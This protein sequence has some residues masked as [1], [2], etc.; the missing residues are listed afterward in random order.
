MLTT[1]TALLVRDDLHHA[2]TNLL[3]QAII[4]VPAQPALDAN[5]EASVFDRAGLFPIADDQEFPF[6][7]DALRVYKS[8]PPFLQR[9]LPFWMATLADRM[10]VLLL[11][12][13]G[14]M[15]PVLRFAPALYTWRVR[16]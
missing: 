13:L 7:P 11:P 10:V 15:L 4:S 9:Y 12:A 5:G 3:T 16:R 14:V 8:G 2:L 6:S 1:T